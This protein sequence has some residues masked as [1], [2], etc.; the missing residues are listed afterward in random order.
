M[1]TI[2]CS[3]LG[4]LLFSSLQAQEY[5]N[6]SLDSVMNQVESNN[7]NLKINQE[8]LNIS[9]AQYRESLGAILPQLSIS[10]QGF[11]TNNPVFAFGSRLNQGI[12]SQ[13]DFDVNA[14]NNPDAITNF[15]TT[16]QVAQPVLNIDKLI[17]RKAS[18]Y[19]YQAQEFQ[20]SYRTSALL[21]KTQTLFMQL[22][23][24]YE[25][26]KV[27]EETLKMVQ[28]NYN[29]AQNFY[30]EGLIQKADVLSAQIRLSEVE[31]QSQSVRQSI[32]NLSDQLKQLMQDE[33]ESTL[34][35]TDSLKVISLWSGNQ[36]E[37]TSALNTSD[38]KAFELKKQS[39]EKLYEAQKYSF[40]PTL[41][42]F[43]Q[44]QYFDDDLFGTSSDNYFFGAELKW[45]LFKGYTRIANLQ[46]HKAEAEKV[47]LEEQNYIVEK[48][49]DIQ[50]SIRAIE[51]AENQMNSRKIVVEQSE[52]AFRI[53]N[54]RYQE[55]LEKTTDL[56]MAE[57]RYSNM[58]L[59]YLQSVFNYNYNLFYYQFLTEK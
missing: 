40:L 16:F 3:L 58:Q 8:N 2:L 15:T 22:Q 52:E 9:Q 32:K 20:N 46:K 42:A 18:R 35:P 28:K 39:Y 36:T 49:N 47:R 34:K 57:S 19:A 27:I 11:R 54:N 17:Q 51:L 59:S 12:F 24:T 38:I 25:S 44:F 55:G 21:L 4:I 5:K 45:D 26:Q 13:S 6:I 30:D 31:T 33:T 41:N 10:H 7:L 1:K 37:E 23:L 29:Q 53:V 56:L 14:L 48:Q 43:G 50:Q